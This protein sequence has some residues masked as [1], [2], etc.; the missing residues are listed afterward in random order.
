MKNKAKRIIERLEQ[1]RAR[2]AW[3]EGVRK[4]AL[5]MMRDY[6]EELSNFNPKLPIEEKTFLNGATTWEEASYSGCYLICDED[7]A[8]MLCNDTELKKTLYGALRPN[9]EGFY[10]YWLDVQARALRQAW[11]LIKETS[12]QVE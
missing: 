7:I 8:R 9:P 2:S 5:R 1:K 11:L 3:N 12:D 4:Y 10:E 6:Y